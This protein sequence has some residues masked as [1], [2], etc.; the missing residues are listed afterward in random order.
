[1][2]NNNRIHLVFVH[3]WSVS[4]TNTYGGLP[5]RLIA[6]LQA[7][8]KTVSVN[9]IHLGRYISF[10]DEVKIKDIACAFQSAV[11]QE[12]T[13]ILGSQERFICITHSTGGPV[14]RT[15]W[16]EF[17]Q[18]QGRGRC[19]MSHL[20]MLAPANYGSAL[21]QL[22]KARLSRI[23]SW[24]SG[25][26]P[27]EGV[28]D[29]LEL[30]SNDAFEL[31]RQ[32]IESHDNNI[33]AN[34]IFPFVITGQSIDRK[35]YDCLNTYT[36]EPGSDGVVRVA[37][38][39]LNGRYL[40][41]VQQTPESV[42]VGKKGQQAWQA[43][44]LRKDAFVESPTTALKIIRGKSH[45]GND[46]GIMKSV[47]ASVNDKRSKD[48]VRAILDCIAV[49]SKADYKA[50]AEQFQQE[51]AAVQSIEKVEIEKN[52]LVSD[53][54]FIHDR[55]S[56]LVI[57][58]VDS[59]GYPVNDFDLLLT[60]GSESNPQRLP[61]GFFQDKQRNQKAKNTITFYLNY[62]IMVGT[63]AILDADKQV[64]RPASPGAQCL[65]IKVIPRPDKGFVH[66]LPCEI[67][68]TSELLEGVLKPNSTTLIELVLQ[69]VVYQNVMQLD[70][71]TAARSFKK[72]KPEGRLVRPSE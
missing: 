13:P 25:V 10:H 19:P 61:K 48:T 9:N 40:R 43:D 51:S 36:G 49:A 60:A 69:R 62:D 30:G 29:W 34:G 59:E 15:W 42:A 57:K 54:Y 26:E 14:V 45:S 35:F 4:H 50:I 33:G 16:N 12:V 66:Y 53:T 39:N 11:E 68:A 58:V 7:E 20:I 18:T 38:A 70:K 5:R 47:K 27:G 23:K 72:V 2:N 65:G 22:G 64:I 28:L 8:G 24:F 21:A 41:L 44:R 3:G 52:R 31:N 46:L 71:G 6:E 56:Q 67:S 1:M 63:E 37:A 17:Y 55:F 32:W